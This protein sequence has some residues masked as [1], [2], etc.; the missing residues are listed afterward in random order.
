MAERVEM[1]DKGR[2]NFIKEDIDEMKKKRYETVN[3]K[4]WSLETRIDTKS[5]DQT[6]TSSA[7]QSK[8]DAL[9]RNSLSQGKMVAKKIVKRTGL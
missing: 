4:L 7:I 5:R 1:T 8:L 6:E 3:D 9:L 2:E